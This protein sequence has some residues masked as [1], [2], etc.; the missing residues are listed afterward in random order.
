[1]ASLFGA[2]SGAVRTSDV[3]G[4]AARR[5]TGLSMVGRAVLSIGQARRQMVAESPHPVIEPL[6]GGGC[7]TSG[8]EDWGRKI[9]DGNCGRAGD[10]IGV[11]RSARAHPGRRL[12]A[13]LA[14]G[15][16]RR[17]DRHDPRP[18]R[19][20]QDEPLPPLP[21]EGRAGRWRSW[22]SASASGRA[23]G[24][25]RRSRRAPRSPNSASWRS[26]TCSTVGSRSRGSKAARSSTCCS[27]RR[28]TAAVRARRR[29]PS[30]RDPDH[31]GRSRRRG[32]AGRPRTL[33]PHLAFPH[34]GLHRD[35]PG[36]PARCARS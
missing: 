25:R 28:R 36:G 31:P 4:L 16:R 10:K 35:G 12:R 24:W 22:R 2:R 27:N 18:F 3:A 34:E 20:R 8:D 21:L 14:A 33:R 6:R 11:G 5:Q 30:G 19:H 23:T 17:R 7:E 13:V 9:V 26:S 15:D 29:G 1:M 32:R